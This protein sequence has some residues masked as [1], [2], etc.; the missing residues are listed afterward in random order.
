MQPS[1]TQQQLLYQLKNER[2]RL[3]DL[4]WELDDI[5]VALAELEA[6]YASTKELDPGSRHDLEHL[7]ERY[8]LME[9]VVLQQMLYIDRLQDRVNKLPYPAVRAA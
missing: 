4:V 3:Q 6:Q 1:S 2:N 9:E 7:R 5:E 8:D